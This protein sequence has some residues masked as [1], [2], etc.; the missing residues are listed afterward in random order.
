MR[1]RGA[2]DVSGDPNFARWFGDS[3]AVDEQGAPKVVYH[4]TGS[5][6]DSFDTARESNFPDSDVPQEGLWF[7]DA[8]DRATWYAGMA[9][10][11]GRGRAP[12]II[13]AHLK[14]QNPYVYK[15]ED[16]AD[17]GISGLPDLYDLK[18]Q[19]YDGVIIERAEYGDG[20]AWDVLG[21]VT[22]R[23]YSVFDPKQVKS[24]IGNSGAWD[25][26]SSSL[27]DQSSAVK[28]ALAKGAEVR[29]RMHK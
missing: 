20:D 5:E 2:I 24:A 15:A 23:Y 29:A 13:P 18:R 7:T 28:A 11:Q 19:G 26:A 16:F 4:G 10:R 17:S 12:N 9:S 6:F 3:K 8:P 25:P 22:E 21:P 1:Q 14:L 27:T